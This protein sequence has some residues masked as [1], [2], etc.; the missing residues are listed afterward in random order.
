VPEPPATDRSASSPVPARGGVTAGPEERAEPLVAPPARELVVD[1]DGIRGLK[2]D[3]EQL[4]RVAGS[5]VPFALQEWHLAWCSHFLNRNPLIPEHPLFCVLREADGECVAIV[6]LIL[7]RRRLGPLKVATVALVGSDP[8]LT[9]IRNPLIKPGYERLAVRAVHEALAEIPDWDWIQWD[10]ISEPMA[11]ALNRETRPDWYG[12]SEDCILDL[13]S[14]WEEF[15][16]GLR[17]NVRESVR[18]CYNSLRREGHAFEMVV[19][20]HPAQ[21][22]PALE[23]FLELH[24][25]RAGMAWGPK[26]ANMF[27]GRPARDFLHD[28]CTRL[29]ARDALRI[30]QLKVGSEIVA[31]R[32]G[33]V[34]GDNI[35]L[36]YSGFDPAWARYS[37]MTTT[38]AE[39]FR[40]AITHG[41]RTVNL[42][43]TAEQSKTRWRPR[44]LK[45][46]SALVH[47]K[48]LRSRIVSAAY[49]VAISGQGPSARMLSA[50]FW[51]HREWD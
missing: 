6:P 36:Y 10:R 22:Y 25:M 27:A 51:P 50:I 39:T 20:Q 48:L 29:A 35:Y 34:T 14:S 46:H 1:V 18:H 33:F 13:P 15:R 31:S 9:E 47:R 23:R 32:I 3:Y 16:A 4:Y 49:R 21:V 40:Y 7:T 8:A 2:A 38:L 12:V 42:S 5:P 28:V 30:F 11:E 24:T 26:H 41:L 43:L 37:V 19:A 45:F 17:R 44:I